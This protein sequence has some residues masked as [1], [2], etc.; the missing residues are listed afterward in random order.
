[1]STYNAPDDPRMTNIGRRLRDWSLDELPQVINIIR[2]EMSFIGPRPD[3]EEEAALYQG[4]EHRKLEARP[5]ISGYAQV[6]G[7]NAILWHQRLALDVEYIQ[8]ISFLLDLRIFLRTFLVVFRKE[9]VYIED[10]D[11]QAEAPAATEAGTDEAWPASGTDRM[12]PQVSAEHRVRLVSLVVVAKDEERCL[13]QILADISGQDFCHS[14]MELLLVD[15]N[16]G[17]NERQRR[18]MESFAQTDHGFRRV[19]VLDNLAGFLPQGCNVAL[20]AYEGDV[21]IRIDAHARI[22]ADFIR[23]TVALLE[24]GHDV[25]GGFRPVILENPSAWGETLLAAEAS[26]FGASPARY[27]RDQQGREVSSVFHGAYRRRVLEE[28]GFYDER[29]QRTEDNDFSQRIRA[30]GYRI[31]MDPRIRSQQYLRPSFRALLRQKAANG[32]W[33]GRTLWLKPQAV[34][35]M[36]FV[37]FVFVLAL[38][39]GAVLGLIVSWLP[40]LTLIYLYAV[41]NVVSS[42]LAALKARHAH[43]HMFALPLVFL[44][45]HV[46]YGA[47]TLVGLVRGLLSSRARG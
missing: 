17:D 36:H 47:G 13:G 20:S 32:Y 46:G 15:S 5:G 45:M 23:H 31:W 38:L 22:P 11:S 34:S 16:A 43:F 39:V 8:N 19:L 26:P 14:A 24:E 28:V 9:G 41:V 1:G 18:L 7:R 10:A 30:A 12:E 40:L 44:A 37:P 29:L 4:D 35:L 21:F 25:C 42:F 27:R 3:L 6:Y 33:I 2:G